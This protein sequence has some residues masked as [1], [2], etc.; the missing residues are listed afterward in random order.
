[1]RKTE[2]A[3]RAFLNIKRLIC[4]RGRRCNAALSFR[5]GQ[6]DRFRGAPQRR[7]GQLRG[8]RVAGDRPCHRTQTKAFGAVIARPTQPAVV[9]GQRFC[10]AAL[11]KQFAIVRMRGCVQQHLQRRIPVQIGFKRLEWGVSVG[12]SHVSC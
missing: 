6:F 8:M 7:L 9:E 10:A 12:H 3:Q 1:M 11:K 4:D 5:C 2:P